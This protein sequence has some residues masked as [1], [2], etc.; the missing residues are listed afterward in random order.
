MDKQ[1][2]K[3]LRKKFDNLEEKN[4]ATSHYRKIG[5]DIEYPESGDLVIQIMELPTEIKGI[6]WDIR[7]LGNE[8]KLFKASVDWENRLIEPGYDELPIPKKLIHNL[9]NDLKNINIPIQFNPNNTHTA[10][11]TTYFAK[12]V[13][14]TGNFISVSWTGNYPDTWKPFIEI[15]SDFIEQSNEYS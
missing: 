4:D 8:Y 6:C 13:N 10:F 15:I 14:S 7:K 5:I 1:E 2:K 12:A 11:G 3:R 9:V